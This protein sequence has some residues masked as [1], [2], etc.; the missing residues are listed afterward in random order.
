MQNA[1]ED[2]GF[3]LKTQALGHFLH[4]NWSSPMSKLHYR[5]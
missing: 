3:E 4:L 1:G 2:A 5:H